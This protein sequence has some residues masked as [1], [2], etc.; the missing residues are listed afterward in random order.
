MTSNDLYLF[1]YSCIKTLECE[2]WNSSTDQLLLLQYCIHKFN[3]EVKNLPIVLGLYMLTEGYIQNTF[4]PR[5]LSIWNYKN[6]RTK[7][8]L[9]PQNNFIFWI[10]SIY[11]K[12]K[13]THFYNERTVYWKG[14][15]TL[16]RSSRAVQNIYSCNTGYIF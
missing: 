6:K 3:T 2:S 15:P 9:Y 8:V 12:N 16:C 14:N 1:K 5:L 11:F 13:T 4:P 7:V 10:K